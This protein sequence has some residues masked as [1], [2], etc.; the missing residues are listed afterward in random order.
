MAITVNFDPIR[1]AIYDW[2]NL[3]LNQGAVEGDENSVPIM[4]AEGDSIQ[5]DVD[6]FVEYKFLTGLV[7]LGL[8]DEILPKLDG[9]GDPTP[10]ALFVQKGQRQFTISITAFGQKA[11]ECI[12]QIQSS[13][14]SPA[15]C[16]ILRAA[17]LAVRSDEAITDASIF[18]E[19]KFEGRAVLDVIFGITFEGE[20]DAGLVESVAFTS[21]L[22]GGKK[23][24]IDKT[25][26]ITVSE[27]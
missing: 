3:A 14:S 20:V 7:K 5:P 4:R 16:E 21:Q 2:L 10:D 1:D 26:G 24:T 17:G 27:P 23:S 6:S 12:A 19:T 22:P 9:N 8:N 15:E 25:T 18:Q 11:P 13:L